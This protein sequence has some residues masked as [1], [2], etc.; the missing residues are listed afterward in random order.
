MNAGIPESQFYMWRAIFAIAHADDVV[1]EEER[2]VMLRILKDHKFSEPQRQ[3]LLKDID[4]RQDPMQ[5]FGKISE[6][7]DRS[8]FFIHARELVWVDGDYGAQE[9]R[10]ILMLKR[11]H[12]LSADF[13]GLSVSK[14]PL[15]LDSARTEKIYP[16]NDA[17]A[18]RTKPGLIGRLI[19][20]LRG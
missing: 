19:K 5:M 18:A 17:V 15:E 20:K 7:G 1:T 16:A 3:I 8:N 11:A 9:Q 14:Q 10:M 4:R 2:E 6:Q 12:V 13:D